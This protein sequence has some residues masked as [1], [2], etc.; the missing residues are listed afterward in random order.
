[1]IDLSVMP[2]ATLTL[3]THSEAQ[4]EVLG[5][6]FAALLQPGTLVALRG[7]LA[8]GKTC[9]TRGIARRLAPASPVTSP[10]FTLVNEYA[11]AP[12]LLHADLYRIEKLSEVRGLGYEELFAPADAIAVVEWAERAESLLPDA[13]I[14]IA[15][16]HAGGDTRTI[17]IA[18]TIELPES[19]Q[20]KL[21]LVVA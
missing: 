21:Q 10:T 2:A 14:D 15:F 5:Y 19:W 6:A 20:Q 16:E 13:R 4:T 7:D 3:T 12:A 18:P 17:T 1:M 9:F 8:A 11:G